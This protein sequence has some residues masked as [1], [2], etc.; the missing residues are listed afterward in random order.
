[1]KEI[2]NAAEAAQVLG[3]RPAVVRFNLQKG[4]WKFGQVVSPKDSGKKGNTYIINSREMCRHF[5]IP[6]SKEERNESI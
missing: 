1:M 5:G 6:F 4:I 2:M 3:C